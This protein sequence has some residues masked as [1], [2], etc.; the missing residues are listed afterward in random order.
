MREGYY[1]RDGFPLRRVDLKCFFVVLECNILPRW[2]VLF[3][4]T[5]F[6]WVSDLMVKEAYL[7]NGLLI[8]A[9]I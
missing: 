7:W 3:L 2:I 9:M 8:D 4:C 5:A 1:K 6:F